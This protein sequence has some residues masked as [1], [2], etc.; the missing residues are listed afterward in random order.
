MTV[1]AR[2]RLLDDDR[3]DDA[4]IDIDSDLEESQAQTAG[5]STDEPWILVSHS[6]HNVLVI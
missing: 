2:R 3:R 1:C 6:G 5:G 4:A